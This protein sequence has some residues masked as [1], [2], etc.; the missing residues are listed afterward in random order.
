MMAPF[1]PLVR[2]AR[3]L[4]TVVLMATSILLPATAHAQL[5]VPQSPAP[6]GPVL[7]A[8]PAPET[9]LRSVMPDWLRGDV[10]GI[11]A[12]QILGLA[13]LII[14]GIVLRKL[15]IHLIVTYVR[16]LT[17]KLSAG[18][19][20]NIAAK[21]DKPVG[22]LAVAGILSIGS[23]LL[24]FPGPVETV[25]TIAV[26]SLAA[27]SVVWLLYRL[28]D[29]IA[30]IL[31][32]RAART[33]TKLDD[34]LVPLLRK[35][36]KVFFVVFGA[37]FILQNLDVDVGSLLAGLGLG[38]LAFAL[39]AK[40]T[41]ANFFGSVMIFIDKPFQ[42][43]DWIKMS[44]DIEGTVEEV[45]FRTSR[46]RTFYNSVITVPNANVTNTAIDNLGAR[47]Y[48]RYRSILSL[49]YDTA[50]ERIEAF[51]EGLRATLLA[52]PGV[53]K[54]YFMVEFQDF[55]AHSLDILLYCFFEV[56]DWQAELRART[57]LNLAVLRLAS[58]IG[59]DFAFPTQTLHIDAV[60]GHPLPRRP[61]PDLEA[62]SSIIAAHGPGGAG[63]L[64]NGFDLSGRFEPTKATAL[65]DDPTH[66]DKEV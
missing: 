3:N 60:P 66:A 18:W 27:Y 16:K 44:P 45:G 2:G 23:P 15:V 36:L 58:A 64:L 4:T 20:D 26:R 31:Q 13:L 6:T 8:P 32:D 51:C 19:V 40:D 10:F 46:I 63:V 35:S 11:E 33:D 41:V 62:L 29:V 48:R 50:P 43:G 1:N 28:V 56:P 53:R 49:T 47:K 7:L 37:I 42:I 5:Q 39:A 22:T 30:D 38:G 9:G 59:V 65:D 24:D 12:W 52:M 25:L 61:E 55:G 17:K 14:I 54:D 21:A 57:N 34:Q